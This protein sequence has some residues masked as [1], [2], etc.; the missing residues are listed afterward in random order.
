M[1][2]LSN[3]STSSTPVLTP[4]KTDILLAAAEAC[5]ESGWAIIP[6]DP[7]GKTPY[8]CSINA[9]GNPRKFYNGQHS[10]YS[11]S[12]GKPRQYADPKTGKF[13]MTTHALTSW[14]DGIPCNVG[15]A[16]ELSGLTALDIDEGIDSEDELKQFLSD[17]GIP[18]T[19]AIR[20][21]RTS[22][23]GVH[24]LYQGV[25][26]SDSFVIEW[27][28][29]VVTGEVKSRYKYVAGE[30]SFHKSGQQYTRLWNVPMTETP[31]SLFTNILANSKKVTVPPPSACA[32]SGTGVSQDELEAFLD[33][34]T[35]DVSLEGFNKAKNALEYLRTEGCPWQ[36]L[37]KQGNGR[38]DFAIYLGVNGLSVHCVH[39]SCRQGW[40]EDSGWKSYKAWLV[41]KNGV[42]PLQPTGKVIFSKTYAKTPTSLVAKPMK[43]KFQ[44]ARPLYT[45][46]TVPPVSGGSGADASVTPVTSV[47]AREK[48]Y[49]LTA[50]EW[51][52]YEPSQGESDSLIGTTQAI[53]RPRTKNLVVAGDKS[54]K[55]TFMMRLA[56]SLASG[57]TCFDEL[58]VMRSCR[59]AHIHAELNPSELKQ[60]VIASVAGLPDKGLDEFIPVRDMQANLISQEG[61]AVIREIVQEFHPEVLILDPWQ[62]LI[63]GFNENSDLD[64]GMARK[65]M[66]TLIED[67]GLTIFLVQHSGRDTSKGGRGHTG[68]KGWRDTQFTLT[69]VNQSDVVKVHVDPRWD[70]PLS[71]QL[72][73]KDGTLHPTSILFTKQQ[74]DLREF[75]KGYPQGANHKQI[76]TGFEIKPMT[77][78]AE[79]LMVTRAANI[80]PPAVIKVGE[81]V[82]HPDYAPKNDKNE[83]EESC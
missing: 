74:Q 52:S 59:V 8:P 13:K 72:T 32:F 28:G 80:V 73:F 34:N 2:D 65:F 33:K 18:A 57:E 71:F 47:K 60:R 27:R 5:L 10:I 37:H 30:G 17:F 15:I 23:F 48:K 9:Q 43:S 39:E 4:T 69:R 54:F 7:D 70:T 68:L 77:Q 83:Q 81:L 1:Y 53:V 78:Q 36:E 50:R 82:F 19:R 44:F 55:T 67:Y 29:K 3:P 22:S 6:L 21:G 11:A 42:I 76:Q 26:D 14:W 16:L 46:D 51:I 25:M 24:L 63:T 38:R 35:E 75:L 56:A 58:P 62:E 61:Q 12:F 79:S 41:K 64:T 45:V 31:T 40:T 66:D 49:R 20:S